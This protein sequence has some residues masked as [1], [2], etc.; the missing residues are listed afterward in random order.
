MASSQFSSINK[1]ELLRK[2]HWITASS[3]RLFDVPVQSK[4]S[5]SIFIIITFFV[6]VEAFSELTFRFCCFPGCLT[7]LFN[8]SWWIS[9][10]CL[11]G[12]CQCH[13]NHQH[14]TETKSSAK[15]KSVQKTVVN[16]WTKPLHFGFRF[17]LS[18]LLLLLFFGGFSQGLNSHENLGLPLKFL[19]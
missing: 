6:I 14:C 11:L 8:V 19:E 16:I 7:A 3:W 10:Q 12:K 1:L 13:Q 15:L 9:A 18:T 5:G 4:M 2:R 17:G